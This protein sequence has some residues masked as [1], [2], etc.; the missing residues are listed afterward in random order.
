[1]KHVYKTILVTVISLFFSAAAFAGLAD[2]D[3]EVAFFKDAKFGLEGYYMAYYKYFNERD[4]NGY[5]GNEETTDAIKNKLRY[6]QS[7]KIEEW[8]E[9]ELS[10]YPNIFFNDKLEFN[11]SLDVGGYIWQEDIAI[12]QYT[13]SDNEGTVVYEDSDKLHVE[14]ANLQMI[15]PIGL[16][17]IGRFE[18]KHGLLYG[19]E[20]PQLPGWSFALAYLMKQEGK[21]DN[22]TKNWDYLDR[23]DQNETALVTIYDNGAGF[24]SQHWIECR[25]SDVNSEARNTQIFIP[26]LEINFDKDKFHFH[27]YTG[28]GF[29]TAA[30]LSKMSIADDIRDLTSMG[31]LLATSLHPGFLDVTD[32]IPKDIEVENALSF[33]VGAGYDIGKFTPFIRFFY[34]DGADAYNEVQ[35]LCWVQ[36]EPTGYEQPRL[37]NS[38]LLKEIEDRYFS[39]LS[40][41]GTSQ[42]FDIEDI[43]YTN[44]S[45]INLNTTYRVNDNWELFGNVIALWRTKAKYYEKNYWDMFPL[46]Y[47]MDNMYTDANGDS[48]I[49]LVFKRK[50]VNYES[51]IDPF[52]GYEING[53]IKYHL[54]SGLDIFLLASYFIAG[55]FYEDVLTPKPYMVQWVN[56]KTSSPV[57]GQGLLPLNGPYGLDDFELKNAWTIQLLVDF[58]FE[59]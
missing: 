8:F 42:A 52:L 34:V 48:I 43:A 22:E 11:M 55:D 58:K 7:D 20:V 36:Y 9:H 32:V 47:T 23:D 35:G 2:P 54:F 38:L 31:S 50:D 24:E 45:G 18:G 27:L 44:I 5:N 29:G 49:P 3:V 56:E 26:Q 1:M 6:T 53:H 46:M 14:D 10:L 13:D 33:T 17:L 51:D 30:E 28:I 39:L 57:A 37:L 41:L 15:T 19:F 16:F 40:T 12:R 4:L 21:D 25:F 59:I